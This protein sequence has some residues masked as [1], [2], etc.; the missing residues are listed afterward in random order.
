MTKINY[1]SHAVSRFDF[2]GIPEDVIQNSSDNNSIDVEKNASDNLANGRPIDYMMQQFA[3]I[4]IGDDEI[5]ELLLLSIGC[6]LCSN[7]D[8]LHVNLSGQSGKGKTDACK[9]MGFLLPEGY[10]ISSSV[11]NKALFY[12]DLKPGSV[13]LIDDVDSFKEDMEQLIKS[14]TSFYQAG[15]KHYS[16]DLKKQG[17]FKVQEVMIPPRTTFWLTSVHSSFDTQVLNR[18]VKIDVDDG[19]DQDRVVLKQVLKGAVTGEYGYSVT[20][21]VRICREMFHQL[22]DNPPCV[23]VIPFAEHLDWKNIEN[24]RN[25]KMFLDLVKASAALNQYQRN[26]TSECHVIANM[27]DF[28]R[29]TRLWK[30]IERAQSTGLTGEEQRV[31]DEI[32]NAGRNGIS[33]K[34]LE[35]KCGMNKGSVSRAIHGKIQNNSDERKGGL[36]NKVV[37]LF[38]DNFYKVWIYD[39]KLEDQYPCVTLIGYSDAQAI[40][41]GCV[42]LHQVARTMQPTNVC[43]SST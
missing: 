43:V 31:L 32:I 17:K 19:S 37:G 26:R 25:P 21:E 41:D 12:M 7:T 2:N 11:S 10:F 9:A 5:G 40:A 27:D 28:N 29:A 13:V 38:Y 14:T 4:H 39:G 22:K 8:G 24:R 20:N 18:F 35:I 36:K 1:Q 33:Q 42:Q 3:K 6:Q 23:V 15:Y 34:D 30:K 16:T